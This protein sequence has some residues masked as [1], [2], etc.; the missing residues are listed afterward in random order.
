[1]KRFLRTYREAS[2]FAACTGVH[3]PLLRWPLVTA[4]LVFEA[5]GYFFGAWRA[6]R[7]GVPEFWAFSFAVWRA[8]LTG[9]FGE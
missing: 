6:K 2:L 1:M 8:A 4:V 3:E 5:P 7:L 9:G